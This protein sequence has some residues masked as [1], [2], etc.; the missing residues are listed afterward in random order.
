[1]TRPDV[2]RPAP[3][4]TVID[5]PGWRPIALHA[6]RTTTLVSLLPMA[7]FYATMARFGL[8]AA[9]L[10]TVGWYYAGLLAKIMRRKPVLAAAMLGAG[11]LSVRAVVTFLTGSAF[12][13]FVQPVAGTVATA[14]AFATTALAGRPIL[15][16]LAHEFCPFPAELS[17]RLRADNF[18]GRISLVWAATY[19]VNAVGTLWL[20]TS[21]SL[22]GFIVLKSVLG[23]VITVAAVLTS[24]LVFRRTTRRQGITV[25]WTRPATA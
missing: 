11:L 12:L 25:R 6:L 19:L 5:M 14:T 2:T 15:D 1:M 20:L 17:E 7:V 3:S 10:T 4:P 18:F 23:P 21:A 22:T 24:Y 13:Y 16:R 9:V 8:R